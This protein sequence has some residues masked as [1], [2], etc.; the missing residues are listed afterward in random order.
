VRKVLREPLALT[1]GGVAAARRSRSP[2]R[3][4]LW[5]LWNARTANY[6]LPVGASTE[7]ARDTRSFCDRSGEV[8]R[9]A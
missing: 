3:G 4:P 6:S 2:R 9:P 1:R 5:T 8:T 7:S